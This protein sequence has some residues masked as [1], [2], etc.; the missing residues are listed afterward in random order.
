MPR[1]DEDEIR[2]GHSGFKHDVSLLV[3][4]TGVSRFQV[5]ILDVCDASALCE[6]ILD[7][8]LPHGDGCTHEIACRQGTMA[9]VCRDPGGGVG[10]CGLPE[11]RGE[12]R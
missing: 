4:Y 7:E 10:R 11:V 6:V 12:G 2:F 8:V 5:D 9:V 1:T 3:L